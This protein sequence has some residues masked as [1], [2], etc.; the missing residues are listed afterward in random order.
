MS[1]SKT[2]RKGQPIDRRRLWEDF[3][4]DNQTLAIFRVTPDEVERLH[5]VFMISA[6][7]EKQQLISALHRMRFGRH[8]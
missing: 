3:Q 5:T 7:T 6:F 1:P 8:V 4:A 2:A